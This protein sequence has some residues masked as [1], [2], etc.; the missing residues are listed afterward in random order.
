MHTLSSTHV[1]SL[2]VGLRWKAAFPWLASAFAGSSTTLALS[3]MCASLTSKR[4]QWTLQK[5]CTCM[6]ACVDGRVS[7]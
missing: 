4:P 2:L 3:P 7:S 1:A 5:E 6:A